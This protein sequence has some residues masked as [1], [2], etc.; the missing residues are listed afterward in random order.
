[1]RRREFIS[2]IGGV[3]ATGWPFAA[4]AQQPSLPV[5]GLLDTRSSEGMASRLAGFR[6]GLKEVGFT[7]GEN[8]TL[9]YRWAENRVDHLPDMAAD[10]VRQQA[11]VIF[12]TGGPPAAFAAKAATTTIPIVFLVPEDRRGWGLSAASLARPAISQAS[13]CSP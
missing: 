9:V 5:V 8:A 7:D 13:T 4:R 12:T 2:L 10:L 11:A 6:Q 3:A 1:M